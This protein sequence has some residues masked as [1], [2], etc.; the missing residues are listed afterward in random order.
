MNYISS[1]ETQIAEL[2]PVYFKEMNRLFEKRIV[3]LADYYGGRL[4]SWDVVNE[5]AI[6][7]HGTICYR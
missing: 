5:S 7:F 1:H 6:D 3:E 4:Q 2:A